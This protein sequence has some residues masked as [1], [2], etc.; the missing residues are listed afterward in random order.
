MRAHMVRRLIGEREGVHPLNAAIAVAV[1]FAI[2]LGVYFGFFVA[3]PGPQA[4]VKV[5]S[6][7]DTVEI[8]YIGFFQDTGR[9]FDTSK[10]AVAKDNASWPK[11]VSFGWRPSWQTFTFK[12][13]AGEAIAGFDQGVRGAR[14]G[15][16]RTLVVPPEQGYGLPDASKIAVRPLLQEVPA[17]ETMSPDAFRV[18]FSTAPENGG[19]VVD[20]F[21]QW[22]VTVA[23]DNN[24]VTITHSPW[25]GQIVRPYREWATTVVGID[26]TANGG[27]GI[28]YVRH[29]L[30]PAAAGNIQAADD[31]GAFIV[32]D[33]DPV[34]GTYT[35]DYNREVVGKTL[36]F[37]ITVI[38]IT[39]T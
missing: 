16:S 37:V 17:R 3:R 27:V 6:V 2:V 4:P 12:I 26:D 29:G 34:A 18:R 39:K 28:V 23:V 20:L 22:N 35:V 10:E 33:V 19:M 15:E 21:W 7:G 5:V 36:V 13:G 14:E 8:D 11:A 25:I 24:I 31:G 30:D 32:T 38:A 9:V 1:V